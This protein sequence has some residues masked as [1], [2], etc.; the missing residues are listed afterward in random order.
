MG[1]QSVTTDPV[2]AVY[3]D[4]AQLCDDVAAKLL[5]VI[6]SELASERLVHVA[7]TGGSV[8]IGV[9]AAL[10][11]RLE[12]GASGRR[13]PDLATLHIWW[14]DERLLPERDT[15]RNAQQATDALLDGLVE[16]YGL[17]AENIHAMPSSEDAA[18]PEV[19]AQQYAE[20]LARYASDADAD[21]TRRDLHIPEFSVVLLGVGPDG[22]IASLFPGKDSVAVTDA[23][24]VGEEDSPKPPPERVSLTVPVIQS[25][26]R[27]WTVVAG[28]DKA[29]AVAAALSAQMP[30]AQIPAVT[31]RGRDESLWHLDSGAASLLSR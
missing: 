28:G 31:A 24:T 27:V 19:G 3:P 11:S 15:E 7:L 30:A 6:T 26:R 22:H 25:S 29:E 2:T 23:P 14:G 9:L 4:K 13:V 5:D 16:S 8:G 10:S 21:A 17:P 1:S 18:S 20:E 12:G